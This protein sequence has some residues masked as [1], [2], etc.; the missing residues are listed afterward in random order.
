M[1]AAGTRGARE[2]QWRANVPRGYRREVAWPVRFE[3]FEETSA[4]AQ[5]TLGYDVHDECC[6]YR[7]RFATLCEILD[8]DGAREA[9]TYFEEVWAWRL[10]TVAWLRRTVVGGAAGN[11]N[12]RR[13]RPVYDVVCARPR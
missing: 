9:E 13:M 4:R 11:C 5:K 8:E 2:P 12:D 10:G 7:H 1:A 3:H 6:F